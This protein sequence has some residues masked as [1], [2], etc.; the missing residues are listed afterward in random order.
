MTSGNTTGGDAGGPGSPKP[1]TPEQPAATTPTQPAVP[2]APPAASPPTPAAVPPTPAAVPSAAPAAAPPATAQPAATVVPEKKVATVTKP[3]ET[4]PAE[5]KPAET[6]TATAPPVP[7]APVTAPPEEIDRL[8]SGAHHNPHGILGAHLNGDVVTFR[9]FRPNAREVTVLVDLLR[10]PLAHER[11]GVW[12][13]TWKSSAVPDYRVEVV[14]D[15]GI[16]H[17]VD[18][19]Y[20]FLPTLGDVDLHLIGE[21]R[22]EQLWEVLGAHEHQYDT[23]SGVVSGTSFAVWAPNARA[24]RVAGDFNFWDS[25]ANPMRSLGS[26]GVWEL[27]IPGVKSG[28]RYKLN[29]LGSDGQWREKAD[30]MAFATEHPPA[31]ASVVF[32]SKYKWQDAEWLTKRA[33]ADALR[34]PMSIYEVHLGSWKQGLGYRQL[35]DE[36]VAYV[37]D[38]GFTHVEFLPVAE[39]PFG[40]SWGYQVSSYFAPTS[41]FGTPDDFRF[42]VDSLHQAGIG[43]IID[44]VPAHFPKD[45]WALAQFDGTHL[46]EHSDPQLGEHPDWGTLVF[47]FGRREV[48]NF[49]VS[50]AI[51]WAE[52]M[53]IDG[54]RVD[55]VASMLYLDYSRKA[56]QWR[57]NVYGG[58]ENL[59]AVSFLQEMNATIYRRA[60]GVVTIAEE[61]TAWP[62]VS[63]PTYVGG[64]GFGFKWNM[65]WM[66]DSLQYMSHPPIY[67]GYHHHEM[68]FSMMYA[69]SENFVLP[70]SHD[71][72][73]H[74][75]GSLLHK[76]PGD[77]WQQVANLRAF[78]AYMW[79]HPGKQLLFMGCEI[80]QDNEWSEERSLDWWLLEY[81]EHN[82][83]Q[84]LVRDLNTTYRATPA[85]WQTDADPEA[86]GGSMPTTRA[87]TRSRSLRTAADG[88]TLACVAN[89]S[90]I[91]HEGYQLGLPHSRPLGRGPEHRRRNLRRQRGGQPGSGRGYRRPVARAG[92]VRDRAHPAARHDLAAGRIN[93]PKSSGRS[94]GCRNLHRG[95]AATVPVMRRFAQRRVVRTPDRRPHLAVADRRRRRGP[96]FV[97]VVRPAVMSTPDSHREP[98]WPA[99]FIGTY[100]TE[101]TAR[102]ALIAASTLGGADPTAAF[103]ANIAAFGFEDGS[104]LDSSGHALAVW[105]VTPALIGTDFGSQ[106][107]PLQRALLGYVVVSDVDATSPT[108]PPIVG[109]AIP[110][111]TASGGECSAART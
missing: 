35:A 98:R 70:I 50:N 68:T 71:E 32:T 44:W 64:L 11:G 19:P 26:S 13:A 31:Q 37:K 82:T 9:T 107:V 78:Y 86:F 95:G 12:S 3:A 102:E 42:L 18:E 16:K 67:R 53:H 2:A 25:Q 6:A 1:A 15:D 36:L 69:Y 85:L 10:I 103:E 73:V 84:R 62:A 61:S 93:T 65:G 94:S 29:V 52:Q 57:P 30:P 55:A 110:F 88:S 104:L 51:Y 24:M 97:A 91:P 56:G 79:A 105:P 22:H 75:K 108:T 72:V 39:H 48:R 21:G 76:M 77:R 99:K 17:V 80:A 101:L 47:N 28:D 8:V 83:V 96:T 20:R 90:A 54:L 23:P 109:F 100:A 46:Y 5:T 38:L 27:F 58:R 106:F 81:A 59:E 7:H 63:K 87:T 89:F 41:R 33:A 74:G 92:G 45:A 49:L 14:Y 34:E 40:G 66:H 43:V 111:N 60:P 4:K